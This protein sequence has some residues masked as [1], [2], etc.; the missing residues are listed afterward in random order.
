MAA[1]SSTITGAEQNYCAKNS[2][3]GNGAVQF[4]ANAPKEPVYDEYRQGERK[5]ELS[6]HNA[7]C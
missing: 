7:L 6:R 5:N 1:N 3:K 4:H 2:L